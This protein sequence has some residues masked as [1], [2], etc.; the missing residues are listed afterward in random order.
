MKNKKF[1]EDKQKK[2]FKHLD[3]ISEKFYA[4]IGH[5]FTDQNNTTVQGLIER[6][7]LLSIALADCSPAALNNV[8]KKYNK[9]KKA[10][11][12]LKYN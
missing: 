10:Q 5:V 1:D 11:G 3:D 8:T 4:N 2:A 9:A 6:L 7:K 12:G